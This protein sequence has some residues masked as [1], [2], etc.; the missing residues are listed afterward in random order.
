MRLG[1][2]GPERQ[3]LPVPGHGLVQPAKLSEDAAKLVVR[4]GL[5]G[6]ESYGAAVVNHGI[7][8][9]TQRAQH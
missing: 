4:L 6:L 8:R 5:V 7:F 9:P 2:V 3:R 1:I